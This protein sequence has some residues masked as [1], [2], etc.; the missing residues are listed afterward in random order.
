M[1]PPFNFLPLL[2][3]LLTLRCRRL[4]EPLLILVV[5]EPISDIAPS[6]ASDRTSQ[7]AICRRKPQWLHASA[8]QA[9]MLRLIPLLASA[10]LCCLVQAS[11]LAAN[12]PLNILILYADDWRYDT[13]GIAGNAVV[14]TP[15]LDQLARDGVR[16]TRACVTTAICGV[17][18]ASLFTGQWMSRHG[19]TAFQAFHTPWDEHRNLA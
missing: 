2:G 8:Q 10:A 6:S 14:Q 18:R 3:S 5:G 9:R 15:H 19:N 11:A 13:L 16:F 4:L 12:K 7:A 17:S 1:I